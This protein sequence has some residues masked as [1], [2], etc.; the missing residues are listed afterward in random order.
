MVRILIG[1]ILSWLVAYAASVGFYTQQVLGGY[2]DLGLE[3]SLSKGFATYTDNF[4]GQLSG[5]SFGAMFLIALAIAFLVAALLKRALKPLAPI[6]YPVAGA[7]GIGGLL[8]LIETLYP[9]VGVFGGARTAV[10][11]GLQMVAG[12]FGGIVFSLFA[13]TR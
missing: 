5:V 12:L 7:A 2:K 4:I 8:A 10:G 11:F 13:R 3:I 1:F 9:G 6:A